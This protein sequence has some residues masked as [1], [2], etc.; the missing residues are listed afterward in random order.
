MTDDSP[1]A[2]R[3]D[4][5][6]PFTIPDLTFN[7]VGGKPAEP[8]PVRSMS[9]GGMIHN[10]TIFA[11]FHE[12]A[13]VDIDRAEPPLKPHAIG[14]RD[15][16][17][18]Q[19]QRDFRATAGI[20]RVR[21]YVLRRFGAD[22]TL[23]TARRLLGDLIRICALTVDAAE[24]LPLEAA[25]DR[26]DAAESRGDESP[27]NAGPFVERRLARRRTGVQGP[28]TASA[29]E[30]GKKR[31]TERGEGR[32]KLIAALTKHHRYA[33]GGCLNQEPVGNN[34]LARAVGVSTSTASDFFRDEFEGHAKYKALC[35]DSG[36][37]VAALKLLNNEFAPHNLYG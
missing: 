35:R 4:R 6:S 29:A 2:G 16:N 30:P 31:S 5:P 23:G 12:R 28:P 8:R 33:D 21:A 26:L 14:N 17:T 32:A 27:V 13:S 25:M 11:D 9:V 15:A 10:L 18:D 24:A 34:E 7:F 20:E 19:M 22:L 36:R 3:G 37:L 1:L